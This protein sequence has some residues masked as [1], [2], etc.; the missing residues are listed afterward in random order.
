M[1]DDEMLALARQSGAQGNLALA[2]SC[3]EQCLRAGQPVYEEY[4][5]T[6]YGH[7]HHQQA[8]A[9]L[10]RALQGNPENAHL[11]FLNGL[12]QLAMGATEAAL[13]SLDDTILLAPS[14]LH[15]LRKRAILLAQLDHLEA[16]L[17]D[18][19][20]IMDLDPTDID[21]V[22]NC[23]IIQLKKQNYGEAARLLAHCNEMA[24]ARPGVIRSLANALRGSRDEQGAL[25][26]LEKLL[27]SAPYDDAARTDYA[28][29]LLAQ[30]RFED[31]FHQY[32]QVASRAPLD[33]WALTGL[34]LAASGRGDTAFARQLMDYRLLVKSNDGGRE[35]RDL[36]TARV[37]QHQ[38]LR[39]EPIGKSTFGGQQTTLLDLSPD[40][41]FSSLGK[42][43]Q[44]NVQMAISTLAH[45]PLLSHHP[46]LCARP[47][48]WR[49]QAWATILHG[50]GGQQRPHTHPAGWLSGVYYLDS[51]DGRDGDGQLIFGYPPDELELRFAVNEFVVQPQ[52]GDILLFPSF[53]LHHTT[54]Y[55]GRN[56]RISIAFDV[57]PLGQSTD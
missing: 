18:F 6:L 53:F 41:A 7:G 38:E 25:L 49:I 19:Q 37:M 57:I 46:W 16:A 42:L 29:T 48:N 10:S 30:K 47:Q 28:L 12:T 14:H 50:E 9:V 2:I 21:A 36:L 11:H 55:F 33:Q 8:A 23:G 40:S 20:R 4:A 26:L 13:S 52:P 35:L 43:I 27:E 56:K 54:P 45:N 34:Y 51:G 3:Y 1:S 24:P 44:Q 32:Q 22:G 39:W 31:A 15:A 17:Q 5:G